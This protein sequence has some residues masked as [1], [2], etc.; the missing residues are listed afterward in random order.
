MHIRLVSIEM[1]K[2]KK[3]ILK[4]LI[5]NGKIILRSYVFSSSFFL[6]KV[7]IEVQIGNGVLHFHALDTWN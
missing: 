7:L 5:E 3:K 2:N 6:P 1:N 4:K